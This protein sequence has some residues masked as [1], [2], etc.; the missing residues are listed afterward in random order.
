LII[1]NSSHSTIYI[2]KEDGCKWMLYYCG[3]LPIANLVV[4]ILTESHVLYEL[5]LYIKNKKKQYRFN[6]KFKNRE[7]DS[8]DPFG[9]EDWTI[10]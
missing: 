1:E 10:L 8:I 3:I 6:K 4:P 5:K 9:E 2:I 7:K